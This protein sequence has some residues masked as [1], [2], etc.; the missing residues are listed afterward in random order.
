[1]HVANTLK[2]M[3]RHYRT[4]LFPFSTAESATLRKACCRQCVLDAVPYYRH[5]SHV[6]AANQFCSL[7]GFHKSQMVMKARRCTHR[8]PCG[9]QCAFSPRR[10]PS[11]SSCMKK[12][13]S[14]ENVFI[15]INVKLYTVPCTRML[16]TP[17]TR[18]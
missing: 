4:M 8:W 7:N 2:A 10:M 1:M 11:F 3:H 13:H 17:V 5:Y 16:H 9:C 6:H 12:C 14:L 18:V 15:I